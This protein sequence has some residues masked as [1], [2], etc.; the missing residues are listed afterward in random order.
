MNFLPAQIAD[1]GQ[2]VVLTENNGQST[3]LPLPEKV[4]MSGDSGRRVVLGI[5][6]ENLTRYDRRQAEETPYLGTIEAVV[7]VVEPTGA[8]TMVVVRI[9]GRE[10]IARFEPHA[11]PPVGQPVKLAVDMAKACLFDP[12]TEMLI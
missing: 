5:R 4:A 7:E 3:R 1:S 8:E 11:A 12:E 6:P 9:A 2:A 10:V